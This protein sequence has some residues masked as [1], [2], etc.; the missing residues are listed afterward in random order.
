MPEMYLRRTLQGFAPDVWS[1]LT[2]E[3]RR[4]GFHATLKAPFHLAVDASEAQVI[5]ALEAFA[6]SHGAFTLPRL[7]IALL[8]RF[9]ALVPAAPS[10]RGSSKRASRTALGFMSSGTASLLLI[11]MMLERKWG[12]RR[13]RAKR[14]SRC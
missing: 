3:P 7:R 6:A 12:R 9:V 14:A 11:R 4:Y 5:A 2:E 8:S 1:A 13:S 10:T